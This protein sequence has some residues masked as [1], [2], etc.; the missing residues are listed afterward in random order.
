MTATMTTAW[1][2]QQSKDFVDDYGLLLVVINHPGLSEPLRIAACDINITSTLGGT[3]PLTFIGWPMAPR[4]PSK[5]EQQTRGGLRFGNVDHDIGRVI[6][7]LKG[8][9]EV[10]FYIVAR[11]T[12]DDLIYDH[13]GLQLENVRSEGEWVLADVKGQGG[14]GLAFPKS[15]C[16]PD[17]APGAFVA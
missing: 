14:H 10:A 11:E 15:T 16:T 5:G 7:G 4:L 1:W 2:E 3:E 12:P 8:K 9:V 13:E 6:L 17:Y